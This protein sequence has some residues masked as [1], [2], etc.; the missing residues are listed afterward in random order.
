MTL[1]ILLIVASAVLLAWLLLEL[2]RGGLGD[3]R[4]PRLRES[5]LGGASPS[6]S[7]GPAV[8]RSATEHRGSE[9]DAGQS[10][11][12]ADKP[13]RQRDTRGEERVLYDE[14]EVEQA[15]RDRLYGPYG[16]RD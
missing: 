11:R 5:P 14:S 8:R 4:L 3:F 10:K 7:P 16:R 6:G 15:V 1:L 12:Q 13:P 9:S 2:A